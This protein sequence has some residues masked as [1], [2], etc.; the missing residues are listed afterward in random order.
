MRFLF[1]NF[2]ALVLL[3]LSAT[4]EA[5]YSSCGKLGNITYPFRLKGD[6]QSCGEFNYELSCENNNTIL[7]LYTGKYYVEEINYGN[8]TMRIVDVGLQKENCSSLPLHSLMHQNFSHG[9]PYKLSASNSAINFLE[10]AAPVKSALYFDT[11]VC[12]KNSSSNSLFPLQTHSYAVD[13]DIRASDV[14]D[15]CIIVMVVWISNSHL[16]IS[17][18]S[19]SGIHEDLLYGTE[20]SWPRVCYLDE[21]HGKNRI[22]CGKILPFS[23][24]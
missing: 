9:D 19:F 22:P 6:Q 18:S 1:S 14:E 23:V 7:H 20:L 10:C 12:S 13:G 24:Q 21:A 2:T 8:F 15:S 5:C 16:K 17:N 11:T 3:L 4:C